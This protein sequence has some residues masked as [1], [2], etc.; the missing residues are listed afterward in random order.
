MNMVVRKEALISRIRKQ[1]ELLRSLQ[2]QL[3][4]YIFRSFPSLG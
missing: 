2:E 1:D 3:E 4:T